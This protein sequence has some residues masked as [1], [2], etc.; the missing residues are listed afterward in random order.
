MDFM[1]QL[2]K[3]LDSRQKG[4]FL[5]TSSGKKRKSYLF[6][7]PLREIKCFSPDSI[8]ENIRII[9][10]YV[11]KG[12]YAAGYVCYEAGVVMNKIKKLMPAV[13]SGPLLYFGIFKKPVVFKNLCLDNGQESFIYDTKPSLTSGQYIKDFIKI[14]RL[15]KNGEVYQVNHCFK[16]KFRFK[17]KAGELFKALCDRQKTQ[18]SGY[19]NDGTRH[20]LSFSP[21]LFFS[22][23]S[24]RISTEPMKGTLLKENM[25][26]HAHDLLD[27]KNKSENVMIVDLI[28]NDLGKICETGSIKVDKLFE[29]KEYETLYQMT[30]T[31]T[32]RHKKGVGLEEIFL[33]LFPSGSVTGAPKIRAMQVINA[34]EKEPRGVYTGAVGFVAPFMKKIIFNIPIRTAV[35]DETKGEMGIGSGIVHDSTAQQEYTECTGKANFLFPQLKG[36]SLI[37]SIL[38]K[39]GRYFLY[40][41]HMNRLL[42]SAEY[43]GINGLKEKA[44][45]ILSEFSGKKKKGKFK[46]RLLVNQNGNVKI[47]YFKI[48]SA[49]TTRKKIIISKVN[50]DS[51][52]IFLRHKTTNRTIY[53]KEYTKYSKKGFYDVVFFNEKGELTEAHSSNIFVKK[54]GLYYTPPVSCGL[55]NGTY[56]EFLMSKGGKYREKL[57]HKYDLL[58]ADGIFLCNS[59][60]GMIRVT[61]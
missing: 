22:V 58:N 27:E 17:G 31:I 9:Q 26:C 35:L 14:K 24:K 32:G 37:E 41:S 38:L 59:V 12:F 56:R 43:F 4:I 1:T 42:Q 8:N 5:H 46:V 55:L 16:L 51:H 2:E 47:E 50:M 25:P 6:T 52:N 40:E 28:R 3:F 48:K 15:I 19:I 7:R 20:I 44:K 34:I 53:D 57:L 18:Y 11:N 60:R 21:E 45:N 39:N 54:R 33:S 61:L 36:H 29:I 49:E 23:S 30:S 13:P 10:H